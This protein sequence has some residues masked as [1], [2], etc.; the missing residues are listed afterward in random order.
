MYRYCRY[1]ILCLLTTLSTIVSC[2]GQTEMEMPSLRELVDSAIQN[3][4]SLANKQLDIQLTALDQSKL[5][6]VYLPKLDLTVKDA[7]ILSSF[8]VRS[9]DLINIPQLNIDIKSGSNRFTT[10]GN[11]LTAD[12]GASMVLYSGGKVPQLR[13]ALTYKSAAQELIMESDRQQITSNVIQ[14]YDQLALLKQV[15]KVLDQSERR[16]EDHRRT[17]DKALGYGLITKY[18]HQKIEVAQAQ[19]A[20]R[21]QEYQGKQE[22]VIDQLAMFTHID[23]DRLRKID[24]E[25]QLI[26]VSPGDG[27]I[28]RR[29]ELKALDAKLQAGLYKIN[30]EKTWFVP[31]VKAGASFGYLGLLA[32]HISSSK[33]LLPGVIDNKLS[34]SLPDINILPMFNVGVGL[35]WD[36]FDGHEGQHEIKAAQIEYK[37][38]ENEKRDATEKLE[39][40]L[41]KCRSEY[42]IARGRVALKST[43]QQ[44]AQ[45]AL[46]QATKEY[47]TG[48]IKSLQLIDAENDYVQSALGYVQS[49]YDQRRAAIALLIATGDL[50]VQAIP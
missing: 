16:L 17:A 24:H 14:A 29:A 9:R 1:T 19:L 46:T 20:V 7:F 33:A 23:K 49:V 45:N 22:L 37:K 8:G 40:N 44:T 41:A 25:M 48:L 5:K 32:G 27:Q 2:R 10:T 6:D 3:D 18:E 47:R 38:T 30:A 21:I 42:N 11:L 26:A 12:L 39:L 15:R 36:L 34:A 50:A 4:Y 13:K 28:A 31:K 35:K 43:E